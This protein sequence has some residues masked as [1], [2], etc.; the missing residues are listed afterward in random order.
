MKCSIGLFL[1]QKCLGEAGSESES[2][3]VENFENE[4]ALIKKRVDCDNIKTICTYH[5]QMY[6]DKFH[7]FYGKV[8]SDPYSTHKK[9]VTSFLKEIT[10]DLSNRCIFLNL[11]PGKSLCRHCNDRILD[12]VKKAEEREESCSIFLNPDSLIENINEACKVMGT[13]LVKSEKLT[14]KRKFIEVEKKLQKLTSLKKPKL[15]RP[16]RGS[17]KR[18]N[19]AE[20]D[21]ACLIKNIKIRLK[22]CKTNSEK[23]NVLSVVPESWTIKRTMRE[24]KVSSYL[25]KK[26]RSLVKEHGIVPNVSLKKLGSKLDPET[27]KIVREFYE[28]DD[29]GRLCPGMKDCVTVRHEDGTKEKIQKR[30]ILC[31]IN[32]L[33]KK[34]KDTHPELKI[35]R[36]KFCELRP[37][38]CVLPGPKGTHSVCVCAIHQNLK[39]MANAIKM[40][41]KDLIKKSVCDLENEECM[42][43][44]CNDCPKIE[45]IRAELVTEQQDEET[46]VS[47]YQWVTTDRSDLIMVCSSYEDFI[48]N[49]IKKIEEVK[50]HHFVA[51]AQANYLNERKRNLKKNECII[52]GD[53]SENYGFLVQDAIQSFHWSNN[54]ATLHPFCIYFI[55][56]EN[57]M[58]TKAISI[59]S[60]SLS[61]DATTVNAFLQ[62]LVPEINILAPEVNKLIF[63]SDGAPAQ[64]KNKKNFVNLCYMKSEFKVDIEWHFFATSHGKG[65]C[66]GIGGTVKRLVA[67]ASL[68][69]VQGDFIL[70]PQ[71]MFNYCDTNIKGIIF[72][73][74]SDAEIQKRE[75]SLRARYS[76]LNTVPH[77][78]NNHCFIPVSQ[79]K[80]KFSKLSTED[81]NKF[82]EFELKKSSANRKRRCRF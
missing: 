72:K 80:I 55:N 21:V 74:V 78:R 71:A 42:T 41:Y 48:D 31:N 44:H 5:Y 49:L 62:A 60:D 79:N 50:E 16:L 53:F 33:F 46:L 13:S 8:C 23:I 52:I 26:S 68:E 14:T 18:S 2:C 39:L 36:S 11:I 20:K 10:L 43:G 75:K 45:D 70:T 19:N 58:T 65:P 56:S 4:L 15:K 17:S 38:W 63:F 76:N 37:K 25:I 57:E 66:D 3:L 64:Y 61:H 69:K 9:K 47:Y 77:T 67:K 54:Q 1:N 82:T 22:S 6:T 29:N 81:M 12:E 28:S 32:E 34:F 35:G 7:F 73:F 30:L 27:L 24:L 59:I 40:D 51:K